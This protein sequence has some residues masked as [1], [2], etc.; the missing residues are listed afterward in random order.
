[1]IEGKNIR[2]EEGGQEEEGGR[3][4]VTVAVPF[5]FLFFSC[6]GNLIRKL[7]LRCGG[8]ERGGEGGKDPCSA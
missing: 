1:M 8:Q 7:L 4:V 5:N 2:Q 3:P 6:I